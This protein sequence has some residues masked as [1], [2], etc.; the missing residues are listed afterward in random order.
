MAFHGMRGCA[1]TW[2]DNVG[3]TNT[4]QA[5]WFHSFPFSLSSATPLSLLPLPHSTKCSCSCSYAGQGGAQGETHPCSS[6]IH[7]AH[8]IADAPSSATTRTPRCVVWAAT[9]HGVSARNPR[10]PHPWSV[11]GRGG[12][13]GDGG[14][15][16]GGGGA[17]VG[18]WGRR[19]G[20]LS[21]LLRVLRK[22]RGLNG[23]WK[24]C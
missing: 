9:S 11:L 14:A 19:Q 6:V 16:N 4:S 22:R 24:R 3:S 15:C 23:S 1:V 2:K 8:Q 10:I 20:C 18:E 21:L 7:A 12:G 13:G 5:P 17:V